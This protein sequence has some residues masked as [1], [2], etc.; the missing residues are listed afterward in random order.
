[1]TDVGLLRERVANARAV[2]IK[3]ADERR[4]GT[5]S[6]AWGH[7]SG[8]VSVLA[9]V[10]DALDTLDLEAAFKAGYHCQWD[11]VTQRYYFDAELKPG[12]PDG[13]YRTWLKT[14]RPTS[15]DQSGPVTTERV[16]CWRAAECGTFASHWV[17]WTRHRYPMCTAHLNGLLNTDREPRGYE[18]WIERIPHTDGVRCPDCQRFWSAGYKLLTCP[19][20]TDRRR[21]LSGAPMTA[22]DF[23]RAAAHLV[24]RRPW[25]AE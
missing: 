1:M 21:Q 6:S 9:Q 4:A 10:L 2:L 15:Q 23:D 13:A 12:D 25:S 22:A 16:P 11:R 17:A 3:E 18:V 19:A 20:C 24:E 14:P 5:K 7:L 8:V